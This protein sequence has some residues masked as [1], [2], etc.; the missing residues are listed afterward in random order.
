[1]NLAGQ[2]EDHAS[3]LLVLNFNQDYTSLAA[4]TK[5][6]YKLYSFN[7]VE[8]LEQIYDNESSDIYLVERLFAS[9]LVAVVSITN[10]RKLTVCHFKKGTEICNY[11]YTNSII[12][13]KL[14]RQRLVVCLEGSLF[15]HNIR[16]MMV[17]HIIRD[18]PYNPHGLCALSISN[19]NSFMAYPGS[20]QVGEVQIFDTI[21]LRAVTMIAA[22]DNP[23]A[24][25]SFN[26]QATKLATASEK[27]TVIRVFSIPEGQKL[28]EFRRGVKRCVNIFSLAF[29][30]DSMYL[31]A[32]SNTET[33]H[34]FKLEIPKERPV[35]ETQGW[36][37]YL[38]QAL[39]T[40]A[41]YLP[42]QVTDMLNQG[43]SFAT[44]RLPNYGFKNVCAI[45]PVQKVLRLV[46]AS[47]DGY[48]YIYNIDPNE[49]GECMLLRQHR[50]DGKDIEGLESPLGLEQDKPL[51]QQISASLTYA[52]S[53][54][55]TDATPQGTPP[56][57]VTSALEANIIQA[58]ERKL[59][60][61]LCHV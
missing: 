23:L 39:K 19:D 48:L 12:G 50:L 25:L 53:V 55:Q 27:G 32:S 30:L 35:E 52:Y 28:F 61:Q 16:D 44:A 7:S 54:K 4:G 46:V 2:A 41:N 47:L 42:A 31:S 6:G 29:S 26:S 22:H 56:P 43:R 60:G 9:S 8:K 17:L 13:I 1:M 59:F 10:P 14:N 58:N 11:S 49:G 3:E 21:N 57:S 24:A 5:K 33:V 15:I 51:T 36:M 18:T 20:T 40:S 38:G 34:I 45:T 37:G